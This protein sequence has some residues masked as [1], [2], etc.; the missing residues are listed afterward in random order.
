MDGINE[1]LLGREAERETLLGTP[2]PDAGDA[3]SEIGADGSGPESS[4]DLSA[5]PGGLQALL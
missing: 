2:L 5:T 1:K 4:G 3:E